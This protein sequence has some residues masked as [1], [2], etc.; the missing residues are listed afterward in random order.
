MTCFFIDTAKNVADY[1]ETLYAMLKPNGVWINFGPLL[2]HFESIPGEP[3]LE[4]T[5]E[6]LKTFIQNVG[7]VI[8]DEKRVATAY[9]ANPR[10]MLV[11]TYNCISFV[12][13]KP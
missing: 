9:T 8:K 11:Y 12:A 2:Y 7:F 13:I 4:L 3:S 5:Y 10:S 1:I 6:E